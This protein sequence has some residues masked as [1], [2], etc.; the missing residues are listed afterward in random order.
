[1]RKPLTIS[2][3][4]A[5]L[6]GMAMCGAAMAKQYHQH[7]HYRGEVY[8]SEGRHH[9]LV[10]ERRSFLDPGPVVPVGTY[11][12]YVNQPAYAWGDPVSTY[13]RSRYMDENLHQAFDPQPVSPLV[14]PLQFWP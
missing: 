2:A 12:Q 10:V 6:L 11:T 9:P 5:C 3:T 7:R 8:A 14:L 13:Q 4:V 1:M